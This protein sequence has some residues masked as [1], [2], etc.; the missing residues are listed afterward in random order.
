MTDQTGTLIYSA[1]A[2]ADIERAFEFHLERD[3]LSALK[4][5]AAIRHAVEALAT[6]PLIGRRITGGLR[7]LVI[8]FGSTGYV[9]LYHFVPERAE[10]WVLGIR[11]Q[12]ELDYAG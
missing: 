12:R 2:L 8:S 1:R 10:I 11:R 3:A 4:A 7:E 6:H 9:A 5:A